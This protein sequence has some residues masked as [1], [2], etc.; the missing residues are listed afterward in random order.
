MDYPSAA[1]LQFALNALRMAYDVV[2]KYRLSRRD[3]K[4]FEKEAQKIIQATPAEVARYGTGRKA[5]AVKK[6]RKSQKIIG[7]KK[8]KRAAVHVSRKR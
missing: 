4:K 1:T 3:K 8:A 7:V 6:S 5:N 2:T